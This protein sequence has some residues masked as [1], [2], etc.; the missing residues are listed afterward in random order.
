M[1]QKSAK[2]VFEP[3]YTTR[4]GGWG[5]GLPL[6][7]RVV[8]EYHYGKLSLLRTSPG[9]G[10]LFVMEIPAVKHTEGGA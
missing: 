9:K 3:G 7:R 2:K 5:L 8:E 6:A 10:S 1:D 4:R